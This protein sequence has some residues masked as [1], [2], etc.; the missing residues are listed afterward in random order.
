MLWLHADLIWKQTAEKRQ[1]FYS[2]K[3]SYS[4]FCFYVRTVAFSVV[5]I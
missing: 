1:K 4:F 2:G 5:K 3:Q